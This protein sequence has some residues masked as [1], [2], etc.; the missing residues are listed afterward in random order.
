ML[1]RV[2][3]G[4]KFDIIDQLKQGDYH[5]VSLITTAVNEDIVSE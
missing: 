4:Q 1:E 2:Y 5:S 3:H